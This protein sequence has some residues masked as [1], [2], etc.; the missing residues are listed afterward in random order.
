MPNNFEKNFEIPDP[1]P[2]MEEKK[3]RKISEEEF[4]KYFGR[5]LDIEEDEGG[6]TLE[7][8]QEQKE[9]T[10]PPFDI[11]KAVITDHAI[12][13]FT[14]RFRERYPDE[15]LVDPDKTIV[16]LL[17][18]AKEDG[19]IGSGMKVKRLMAHKYEEVRYFSND[20]WRFVVVED[21]DKFVILTI[22]RKKRRYR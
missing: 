22:E 10:K 8:S 6:K 20:G 2:D 12:E 19:A 1:D 4:E 7:I 15:E 14:E 11:N 17:S 16:E 13:R 9:I 5:G 3:P 21:G 18:R